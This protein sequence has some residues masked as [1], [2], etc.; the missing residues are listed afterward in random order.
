MTGSVIALCA[1]PARILLA[2]LFLRSG[3]SKIASP[4]DFRA[5]VARFQVVPATAAPVIA[6]VL[7]LIEV[8]AAAAMAAGF[9]TA[10]FG[11]LIGLLLLAFATAIA[12]NL[13]RGDVV[14]CGCWG[15][16]PK[17]ITWGQVGRNVALAAV[18]L[19]LAAPSAGGPPNAGWL[20][21]LAIPLAICS[22]LTATAVGDYGR[23]IL[24]K[25]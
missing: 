6:R 5:A 24:R 8:G 3:L 20:D 18:A 4:G 9:A 16:A 15:K 17:P 22:L 11:P 2:A 12:V 21:H 1:W 25:V 19:F 23:Q 14:D 13:S 7:P 10:F